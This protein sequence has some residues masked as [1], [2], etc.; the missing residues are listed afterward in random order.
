MTEEQ[1]QASPASLVASEMKLKNKRRE[2]IDEVI[3]L[4]G[5]ILEVRALIDRKLEEVAELQQAEEKLVAEI[6]DYLY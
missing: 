6:E 2:H 3:E 1:P 5:R 4:S